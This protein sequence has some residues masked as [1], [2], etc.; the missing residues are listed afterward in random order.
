VFLDGGE[1]SDDNT[2]ADA[3]LYAWSFSSMPEQSAATLEDAD[4]STPRFVADVAGTYTVRLVVTDEGGLESVPD[5]VT[6]SSDNMAPTADAG[7]DQLVI[8]GSTVLLDGS[9]SSDPEHDPLSYSWRILSAPLDSGARLLDAETATPSFVADVEGRY[10]I[11]LSVSD[12]IGPGLSDS[13]EVDVVSPERYSVIAIVSASETVVDLRPAQVTTQGNRKA[14]L[15]FLSQA[16]RGIEQGKP[17]KA[18]DKLKKAISR[19]DGCALRGTPDVKGPGRDWVI[20]CAAQAEAYEAL[21][22]GLEA[23][24]PSE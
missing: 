13:T 18:V 7:V 6:I 16:V 10:D 1:S 12:R 19:I 21:V 20:D 23:L 15:K 8:V 4:T 5:E 11:S 24:M 22:S 3:L 17:K 2:A 14:L 9:A